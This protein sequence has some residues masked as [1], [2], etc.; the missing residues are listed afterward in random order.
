MIKLFCKSKTTHHKRKIL[1][2]KLYMFE[3]ITKRGLELLPESN[4]PW[5]IVENN[6]F[7]REFEDILNVD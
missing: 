6:A 4:A 3:C 5:P 7:Y 1:A 2:A